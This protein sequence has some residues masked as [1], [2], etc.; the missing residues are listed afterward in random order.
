MRL[1]SSVFSYGS[2]QAPIL[3]FDF[4]LPEHILCPSIVYGYAQKSENYRLSKT[5]WFD[6]KKLSER[7]KD[8]NTTTVIVGHAFFFLAFD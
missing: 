1:Y 2:A 5:F 4:S 6:S 8:M 3:T 7:K